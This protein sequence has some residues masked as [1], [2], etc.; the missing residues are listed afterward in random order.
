MFRRLLKYR[1]ES[2][3][4]IQQQNTHFP[5]TRIPLSATMNNNMSTSYPLGDSTNT[6]I[7]RNIR[8]AFRV[9]VNPYKMINS[10]INEEFNE[11][12]FESHCDG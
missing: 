5:T 12:G 6:K 2:D 11:S 4:S 9:A 10:N 8:G 7:N 1:V 3:P